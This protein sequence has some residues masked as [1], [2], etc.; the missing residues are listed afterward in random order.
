M[1]NHCKSQKSEVIA[2]PIEVYPQDKV[3]DSS[4]AQKRRLAN[5]A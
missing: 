2:E 4:E 5:P 3:S 1:S